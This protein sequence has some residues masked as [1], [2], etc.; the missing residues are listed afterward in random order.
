VVRARR[1]P[2]NWAPTLAQAVDDDDGFRAWVAEAAREEDLGR[3]PW[4]WLSRPD[5]WEEE[6]N[7][8]IEQAA[9][10]EEADKAARLTAERI[11]QLE[12]E[13]SA[14][15]EE[16]EGLRA[17]QT[18]SARQAAEEKAE[19]ARSEAARRRQLQAELNDRKARLASLGD[20]VTALLAERAGL[21]PERDGLVAERVE[22]HR[23][24]EA[25]EA[26]L[27][28]AG[29]AAAASSARAAAAQG[30][31]ADLERQ[32]QEE[33]AAAGW[34][35]DR[36]AAAVQKAAEAAGELGVALSEAAAALAGSPLGPGEQPRDLPSARAS[37]AP[38]TASGRK[39]GRPGRRPRPVPLPPAVFEESPEAA[40]FLV[41][42]PEVHL[43]VD[44]Y[45][46]ALT[47]WGDL[48]GGRRTVPDLPYL[49]RRLLD[50]ISELAVR[51]QRQVT[52]V[53]DGT[54]AGG[55]LAV[56]GPARPWLRVVFS[57]SSVE[58][59]EVIVESAQALRPAGPVVVAT[60]DRAVRTRAAAVGANVI[61]V[62]QLLS[63]LNRHTPV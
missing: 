20:E 46:V 27:E 56:S 52:V 44:G 55:R 6:V 61:S 30:E 38:A 62:E 28:A 50:A 59:D 63:V 26:Q 35:R 32:R 24:V 21:L 10:D 4:L 29:E 37:A 14:A 58:A 48:S 18:T 45:N 42:A 25:L 23:R 54:D 43:L 22:L 51:V 57:P 31:R 33:Q 11:S 13:L 3:V 40:A 5:G 1:R 19:L 39:T 17:A 9:A 34:R 53:F 47:S 16:L 12:H 41:R 60:D 15:R 36:V 7:G 8:L 49:R 2:A